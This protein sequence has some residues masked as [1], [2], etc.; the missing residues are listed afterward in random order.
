MLRKILLA[1]VLLLGP[2]VISAQATCP[3]ALNL[4]CV[5]TTGVSNTTAFPMV[6]YSTYAWQSSTTAGKTET[7]GGTCNSSTNGYTIIVKDEIGTAGAY[8]IVIY[9]QS[10]NTIDNQGGFAITSNFESIT[11]QCD[12]VSNWIIE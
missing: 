10:G 11:L 6:Q 2:G 8:G 5:I 9:P 3:A 7:I 12:G 1:I 4:V